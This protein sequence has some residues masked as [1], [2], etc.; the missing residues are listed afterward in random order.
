[1]PFNNNKNGFV[2]EIDFIKK[3]NNKKHNQLDY[4]LQLFINELYNKV[5]RDSK[6]KCCK[7]RCLQKYDIIY[8]Y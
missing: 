6:I 7:N 2:N 8:K 3:I 1:M 4:K 5:N